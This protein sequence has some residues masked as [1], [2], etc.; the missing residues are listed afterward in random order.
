MAIGSESRGGAPRGFRERGLKGWAWTADQYLDVIPQMADLGFTFL[1]NCYASMADIEHRPWGSAGVNRWW[2]PLPDAKRRAYELVVGETRAHGLDFWFSMNPNLFSERVASPRR[3]QD[4]DA[5]WRHYA[6]MQALGV[7]TFSV[8]LDDIG[9]GID[10]LAHADLVNELLRRL[11]EGDRAARMVFCPTFYWGDGS[12]DGHAGYLAHLADRLDPDVLV[13]WTGDSVVTPWIN[14]DTGEQYRRRV[15]HELVIWDNYPVNDDRPTMHLGPLVGRDPD[16]PAVAVA[17][18]A[19]PMRR[20]HLLSLLPLATSADYAADPARYEPHLAIAR[21]ID[22]VGRNER[23]R[24]VLRELV[25]RYPGMI[26]YP[27]ANQYF[28]PVRH[29]FDR[30]DAAER[31]ALLTGQQSLASEFRAALGDRFPAEAATLDDDVAWLAAQAA[32]RT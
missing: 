5:L 11:R 30:A 3:R 13:F 26:R 9:H 8:A 17:Y 24:R 23:E 4:V 29:Q 7:R 6:W 16:L 12:E 31:R 22:W 15:R 10:A 1:A 18:M 21:A 14:R 28:N 2:E 32:A 19:N 27:G 20:Q 25:A